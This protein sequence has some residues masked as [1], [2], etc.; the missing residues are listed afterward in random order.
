MLSFNW[1][2]H[3]ITMMSDV[4]PSTDVLKAL[5][6]LHELSDGKRIES[7]TGINL[8]DFLFEV[9][10]DLDI[11]LEL[12]N[13]LQNY[14]IANEGNTIILLGTCARNLEMENDWS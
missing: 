14:S 8:T 13:S 10:D 3:S 1:I 12:F 11:K 5:L 7:L 6:W 9:S 2:Y 4:S